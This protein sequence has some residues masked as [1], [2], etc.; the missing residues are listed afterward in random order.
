[1]I[2]ERHNGPQRDFRTNQAG[3]TGDGIS[4]AHSSLAWWRVGPCTGLFAAQSKTIYESYE[5]MD[6]WRD[7][8]LDGDRPSC[9][10]TASRRD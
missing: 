1:M 10:G 5:R 7:V 6:G 3:K 2:A 4:G 8:A 9:S